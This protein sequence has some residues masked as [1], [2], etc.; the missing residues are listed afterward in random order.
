MMIPL[1]KKFID[2]LPPWEM[3]FNGAARQ[4]GVGARVVLVLPD[5]HILLYSFAF[6][7]LCP[8][9]MAEYQA[10]ILAV[11]WPWKWALKTWMRILIHN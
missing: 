3:Y 1:V 11:K 4:D 8:N 2:N 7:R 9:N 6:T 10:L 5:K